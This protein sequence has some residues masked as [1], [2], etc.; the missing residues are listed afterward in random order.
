M[1]VQFLF[2]WSWSETVKVKVKFPLCLTK[3]YA[4]KKYWGA[5]VQLH[6]FLTS[7]QDGRWVVSFT[8]RPPYPRE[9][10]PGTCWI[11]GWVGSRAGLDAVE[12]K[13]PSTEIQTTVV[14]PVAVTILTELLWC[15]MI[16]LTSDRRKGQ[17]KGQ[18]GMPSVAGLGYER[19]RRKNQ[20][21]AR[22][23]TTSNR[24]LF[25]PSEGSFTQSCW[26]ATFS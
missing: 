14:Q 10:T 23:L 16:H 8:P 12:K 3:N 6:A 17:N 21:S 7:A 25:W 19:H 24:L 1:T 2:D 11:G 26:T 13:I 22:S 4:M 5:E 18:A 20:R 9:K 15:L